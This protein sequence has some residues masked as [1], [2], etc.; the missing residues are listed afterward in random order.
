MRRSQLNDLSSRTERTV[1]NN[2]INIK[3]EVVA[4]LW[5]DDEGGRRYIFFF[6]L[7]FF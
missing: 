7:F 5:V 4:Y 1:L 6:D 3:T 2:K